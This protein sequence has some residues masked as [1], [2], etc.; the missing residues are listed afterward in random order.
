MFFGRGSQKEGNGML[1]FLFSVRGKCAPVLLSAAGLLASANAWSGT[2]VV[3]APCSDTPNA[4]TGLRSCQEY[5]LGSGSQGV[6]AATS[7]LGAVFQ[8]QQRVGDHIEGNPQKSLKGYYQNVDPG[9]NPEKYFGPTV[10]NLVQGPF[11][12]KGSEA[13][14]DRSGKSCGNFV[15]IEVNLNYS[16]C[17][18]PLDGCACSKPDPRL[19][20]HKEYDPDPAKAKGTREDSYVRGAL[21][22][23]TTCFYSQV[24]NELKNKHQLTI[25]DFAPNTPSYCAALMQ[26]YQGKVQ[27]LGDQMSGLKNMLQ[28][29]ANIADIV[30]CTNTW[31]SASGKGAP[32]AGPLRQSA[33]QLCVAR[34]AIES[35]FTQLAACEIFARSQFAYL[36]QIGSPAKQA[37]LIK[38]MQGQLTKSCSDECQAQAPGNCHLPTSCP[39]NAPHCGDPLEY[40][41]NQCANNCYQRKAVPF[42][43]DYIEKRW[44]SD[45]SKCD[46]SGNFSGFLMIGMIGFVPRRRRKRAGTE[47]A[48]RKSPAASLWA[49][50]AF[51]LIAVPGLGSGAFL[52]TGCA[53]AQKAQNP[54]NTGKDPSC[55]PTTE[56]KICCELANGI[57]VPNPPN[58][59]SN[60]PGGGGA[61]IALGTGAT[62][63]NTAGNALGAAQ[64]LTGGRG[65][66]Q[67]TGG[68][69]QG[70]SATAGD[71]T[72]GTGGGAKTNLANQGGLPAPT[73]SGNRSNSGIGGGAGNNG[74]SLDGS[75]VQTKPSQ[76]PSGGAAP[77]T[78][79]DAN[80]AGVMSNSN[81]GA[82]LAGA[83]GNPYG[84]HGGPGIDAPEKASGEVVLAAD[85]SGANGKEQGSDDPADYFTRVGLEDSIF[86][87]VERRYR[88]KS[89]NWISADLKP[90]GAA[91]KMKP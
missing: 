52:A 20:V 44:P 14:V 41:E 11:N 76:D 9:T 34:N 45:G 78:T 24:T 8:L 55:P 65:T 59:S 2:V 4:F 82:G 37:E 23:A 70:Q 62:A 10:C 12:Q 57:S 54:L 89:M 91:P 6:G 46:L 27:S 29:Q 77:P 53:E 30:N 79:A 81:G 33:Q 28:G 36:N 80:S 58:C 32:D 85:A 72:S 22:Q 31:D 40:M 66:N 63:G 50:W 39:S 84:R 1:C 75:N 74:F 42:F 61:G 17:P 7:P 19:V 51:M 90:V 71:M 26:D 5:L 15:N 3:K 48:G 18:A 73:T 60:T 88:E 16:R 47:G 69:A 67:S 86:K 64:D 21:L 49:R 25:S 35:M 83:D 68:M 43:K 87:V 38:A 56:D 13:D